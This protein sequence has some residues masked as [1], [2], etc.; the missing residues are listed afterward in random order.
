MKL[1]FPAFDDEIINTLAFGKYMVEIYNSL[2]LIICAIAPAY[3]VLETTLKQIFHNEGIF[4]YK[5]ATLGDLCAEVKK[6]RYLW[7]KDFLEKNYTLF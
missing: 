6:T 4:I 1:R 3:R 2:C 5:K 7:R